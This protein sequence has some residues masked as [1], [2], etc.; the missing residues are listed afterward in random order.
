MSLTNP[1]VS[2]FN[3]M[4]LSQVPNKT[5]SDKLVLPHIF[6][7][8][9]R[10]LPTAHHVE[11]CDYS[12]SVGSYRSHNS[13][14]FL[15]AIHGDI[16]HM[17]NKL[18]WFDENWNLDVKP[19]TVILDLLLSPTYRIP[20]QVK[21][22]CSYKW[23]VDFPKCPRCGSTMEREYQRF[24]DRCG[25]RLSWR[26]FDDAEVIYVGWDGPDPDNLP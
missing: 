5:I 1:L 2:N 18:D 17:K 26:D 21:Q 7:D 14:D 3:F 16:N 20:K 15:Y 6:A 25:Q 8:H 13:C 24:C 11:V 4:Q 10:S 12:S 22:I 19:H 23:G 9:N